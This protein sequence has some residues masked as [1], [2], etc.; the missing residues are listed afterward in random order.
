M[1]VILPRPSPSSSPN[2]I[3]NLGVLA[4]KVIKDYYSTG[5]GSTVLTVMD[6]FPPTSEQIAQGKQKSL[7]KPKQC[8]N[9]NESNKPEAKFCSKCKFVLSFD[10]FNETMEESEKTKKELEAL[11]IE[12]EKDKKALEELLE[13][14]QKQFEDR[15]EQMEEMQE[16]IFERLALEHNPPLN[17]IKSKKKRAAE[18]TRLMLQAGELAGI[19]GG[20][21]EEEDYDI[22]V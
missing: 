17:Q 7:L 5:D 13:S 1:V 10:A 3:L 2:V 22:D 15:M 4:G 14:N 21:E 9:C 11:K 12:R 8:P 16:K 18:E 19:E 6:G 20:Q